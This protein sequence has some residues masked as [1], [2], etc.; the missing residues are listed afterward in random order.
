MKTLEADGLIARSAAEH[1]A[2]SVVLSLTPLGTRKIVQVFRQH[3]VREADWAATLD[4]EE[5][6]TMTRL[7]RKLA[8]AAQED[9]VSHRF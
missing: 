9:W 8:S 2:R 6:E 3:N 4:P 1:D 5:R 7:L